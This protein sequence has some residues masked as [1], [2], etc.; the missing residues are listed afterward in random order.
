M[1][2]LVNVSLKS[3]EESHL[4]PDSSDRIILHTNSSKILKIL[5]FEKIKRILINYDEV[6]KLNKIKQRI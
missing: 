3:H 5:F 6:K 2:K 4:I 1:I